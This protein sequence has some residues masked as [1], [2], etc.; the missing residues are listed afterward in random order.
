MVS[1]GSAQGNIVSGGPTQPNDADDKS[2]FEQYVEAAKRK[3][4]AD[5]KYQPVSKS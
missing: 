4:E 2:P 5:P 1:S 3:N